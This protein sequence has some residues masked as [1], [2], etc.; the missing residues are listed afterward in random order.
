[1]EE[2]V[3]G[4]EYCEGVYHGRL[5]G[6]DS[7]YRLEKF[8]DNWYIADG[9]GNVDAVILVDKNISISIT[10]FYPDA[11][12]TVH[13]FVIE[14][15]RQG[16][17]ETKSV[18]LQEAKDYQEEIDE[19]EKILRDVKVLNIDLFRKLE[20]SEAW[21]EKL[22]ALIKTLRTGLADAVDDNADL[23]KRN[24]GLIGRCQELEEKNAKEQGTLYHRPTPGQDLLVWNSEQYEKVQDYVVSNSLYQG[25]DDDSSHADMLIAEHGY[26]FTKIQTIRN[27][28]GM[29]NA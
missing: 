29:K 13:L 17:A 26:L 14:N 11:R 3:F 25:Y 18:N 23:D 1:M 15:L 9:T 8:E 20:D 22:N 28:A 10:D 4:D 7:K 21:N 2:R 12:I 6:D 27:A 16:A 24:M 19:I 5:D